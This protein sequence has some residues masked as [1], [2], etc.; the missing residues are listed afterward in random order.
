[1]GSWLIA[2]VAGAVAALAGYWPL[3]SR[4]GWAAR[5]SVAARFVAVLLTVA[6]VVDA[7]AAPASRLGAFVALDASASW[8]RGG[9]SAAWRTAVREARDASADSVFLFGDTVR[10]GAL[11]GVPQDAASRVQPAV[12]RALA[13]GRA[14]VVVT[15]GELSDPEALQALPAGSQL[16]IPTRA[17]T[18]DLAIA[19]L[20][21]PSAAVAG[22]SID[23]RLSVAAGGAGSGAGR[24]VVALDRTPVLD[25]PL[26]ALGPWG[27]RTVV[28]RVPLGDRSGALV[29]RA[30]AASAQDAEPVN[31]T[32]AVGLDVAPQASVVF[33]SSSPDADARWIVALLRG[34]V[35]LPTRAYLRV[36]PG[37]W[38]VEGSLAPIAE[39]EVRRLVGAAPLA[40]L[41]GD[42]A[43]FGA[44]STATRGALA[45]IAPP[46]ERTG[47]WYAIAAPPSPL[48][49]ALGGVPWDSLPPIEVGTPA[50]G[51][52]TGLMVAHARGERPVAAVV[53]R[54]APRRTVV[55]TATGFSAWRV[56]AGVSADAFGALW[57]A[58][59]DWLAADR[60]DI[61]AARPAAGVLREGDP[62]RW[63]RGGS[64]DTLVRV[65][66][67][68]RGARTGEAGRADTLELRFARD[69]NEAASASLSPGTYDVRAPGGVS[70]LVVNPSAEWVARRP[71][72]VAGAVGT[73]AASGEAPG[74]RTM[75]W[76]FALV[77]LLLCAEW[78]LRRR[79]GLR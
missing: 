44:P 55:V 57:G 5:A 37:Q 10:A 79:A 43:M 28:L 59:A 45:L 22:D 76:P 65:V 47:E 70:V 66:V 29:L 18:R 25:A 15:D 26:E 74:V 1:M 21:A 11:P 39:A 8:R 48:A 38:R 30:Y 32:L 40:V 58:A 61:R 49:G 69:V 4:T 14:L 41:H 56:R 68:R 23:V 35:G 3:A 34:A 17:L 31:D 27:E 33:A 9:D 73:G 42:T 13:A 78:L 6:L 51:D 71:T 63:R 72:V 75:A 53:G 19:A 46:R 20:E 77:V 64:S 62:V 36:A 7:P 12:E 52:W 67:A 2:L 60:P 16:I 24:L 54:N 50:R